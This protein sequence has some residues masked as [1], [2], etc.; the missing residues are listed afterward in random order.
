MISATH[1]TFGILTTEFVFTSLG[2]EPTASTL[3][4][5]GL[6][7]MLP[8]ID[9]PKSALGRV[10]PLSR[11]IEQRYGHRQATHSWLFIVLCLILFSPVIFFNVYSYIALITG[12][13]SHIMLDMANPSGVPFFYPYPARFVFPEDKSSRIEVNSKKEYILLAILLFLLALTTPISFIGYKSLFFRLAKTPYGAVEEVKKYSQDYLMSVRIKGIWKQSQ[14]LVED[15]FTVLAVQDD[16]LIVQGQDNRA[17]FVSY[18]PFSAVIVNK[19]SVTLQKK[20]TK[21]VFRKEYEYCLF[22]TIDIP[23]HSIIS[24]YIFYEG[25]DN[26]KDILWS[27]DEKEYWVIKVDPKQGNKLI[28]SYCPDLFLRQLQNKSLYVSHA[29]LTITAYKEVK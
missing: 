9:T 19:I 29:V 15:T 2:L 22:D 11:W 4:L 5:S 13:S 27:F 7:A 17:Y 16:G 6:G 21:E 20:V 3:A 26:I 12:I 23:E 18:T 14:Q 28:L 25:Y 24:G 1:I 10:F 8:D